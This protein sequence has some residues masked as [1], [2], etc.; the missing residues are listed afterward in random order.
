MLAAPGLLAA[1]AAADE[2]EDP[3]AGAEAGLGTGW[4]GRVGVGASREG[5]MSR[6]VHLQTCKTL[7]AQSLCAGRKQTGVSGGVGAQKG[8][9]DVREGMED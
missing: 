2:G 9:Q 1:K 5:S 4:G 8:A 3:R 6:V 7:E